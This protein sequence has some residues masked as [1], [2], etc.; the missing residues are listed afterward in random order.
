M[1]PLDEVMTAAEA[2]ERW[3]GR[4]V[5]YNNLVRA[6]KVGRRDSLKK[7]LAKQDGSG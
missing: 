2:G 6:I 7:R 1:N 5:L 3:R 4:P